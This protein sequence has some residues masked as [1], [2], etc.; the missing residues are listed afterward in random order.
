MMLY[1]LMTRDITPIAQSTK[2]SRRRLISE[3]AD[4]TVRSHFLKWRCNPIGCHRDQPKKGRVSERSPKRRPASPIKA[5]MM[6][7]ECRALMCV[8]ARSNCPPPVT[9]MAAEHRSAVTPSESRKAAS[10]LKLLDFL[11]R[12]R[13]HRDRLNP[14][15]A[16]TWAKPAQLWPASNLPSIATV[17][18]FA[19][20]ITTSRA[21]R[22][23]PAANPPTP[24]DTLRKGAG[25]YPPLPDLDDVGRVS[26]SVQSAHETTGSPSV[27]IENAAGGLEHAMHPRLHS[28]AIRFNRSAMLL[29]AALSLMSLHQATPALAQDPGSE[30]ALERRDIFDLLDEYILGRRVEPQ[31]EVTAETGLQ[32]AFVPTISYNPVYGAAF[33]ALVSGAGRRGS[34]ESR[35]SSLSISGNYSTREQLQFQ[36]RGDVFSADED[37]LLKADCRY[38]DTSRSTWG[39]GEVRHQAGEYPMSFVLG[40]VYTTFLRRVRGPVYLGIGAHYDE[41]TKI[42]D[43]RAQNG[44]STPFVVYSGGSPSSTRAV[45]I[46]F[47]L[48]ADTRDNLVD[49]QSGYYLNW[50]LRN[51]SSSMG[52]DQNWQESWIEARVYPHLPSQSDNVLAFWMYTWMSFG[53]TPYLNLPANGWDTYGRGARGYLAG[54]IRGANQIYVESE[55]RWPLTRDGLLGAV[56]FVNATSTTSETTGTFGSL[57]PGAGAGLRI[58]FN[59]NTSTNLTLDYAWGRSNSHGLFMGMTEVF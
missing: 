32:W 9:M 14:G 13:L 37:F 44:E 47:N 49:P 29:A 46:S 16:P 2:N 42:I 30:Q 22:P 36:L 52:S 51:Y 24:Y 50:S 7:R 23:S 17:T 8:P 59:K 27:I 28:R 53:P 58:K 54:R 20:H 34:G 56:A 10:G 12:A 6:G 55:Y 1:T 25:Q 33:G 48:L 19:S 43:E 35:Y 45:G 40:R 41:F 39:L 31:F 57:D 21:C 4:T 3:A 18:V 5:T 11:K 26:A 38:L 15:T